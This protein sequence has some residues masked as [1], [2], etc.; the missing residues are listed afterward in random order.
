MADPA[1]LVWIAAALGIAGV[2]ALRFAWSQPRR[3]TRANAL[4]WAMLGA[5]IVL[6]AAGAGAWGVAVAALGAMLAAFAVLAVAG[7]RSPA[8]EARASDRRVGMLPE[9]REPWRI[10][11]RFLSFVLTIVGGFVI[12]V[13]LAL[14]IIGLGHGLGWSAA[15]TNVFALY[16][17]PVIWSVLVVVLLMSR[18]RRR[19][20]AIL[21]VCCLPIVPVLLSGIS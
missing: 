13:G 19:Q 4:G 6:A 7:W 10:G 14:A 9:G 1:A 2:A 3:S 17:V 5:S 18:S 8:R 20:S 15:N 16:S 21:L 12:S 11:A